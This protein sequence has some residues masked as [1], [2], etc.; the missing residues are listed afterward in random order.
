MIG[1]IPIL[2]CALVCMIIFMKKDKGQT[3]QEQKIFMAD[4][5]EEVAP[6]TKAEAYKKEKEKQDEK[7]R[8][9]QESQIMSNNAFYDVE[10]GSKPSQQQQVVET[11][12]ASAPAPVVE[13]SI[14]KSTPARA[15]SGTQ[16]QVQ[17]A[18]TSHGGGGGMPQPRKVVKKEVVEDENMSDIDRLL[19]QQQAAGIKSS[20][21]TQ[22]K[23]EPEQE[24]VQQVTVQKV[25]INPNPN[26]RSRNLNS[27]GQV[28]SSNLISAVI[29]NDQVISSGS[30]VKLRLCESIVVDGVTVPRNSFIT[31][32]ATFTKSRINIVLES[33]IVGNSLL[34]FN[35]SVY[36]K[37]GMQGINLPEN[38]KSEA[39]S[40][41]GADMANGSLNTL[42]SSMGIVG[43][44]LNS[45]KNLVRK[46]TQRQSITL[47]SNY[48]IFLK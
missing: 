20:I 28:V 13:R 27:G 4:S 34:P 44:A 43:A 30:N 15:A 40:E 1:L 42:T 41:A 11:P 8:I 14:P 10:G 3:T 26:G 18:S 25:K 23:V 17:Y 35:K 38:L 47:K 48:K 6:L 36:D 39:A 31:G 12:P 29:H 21:K 5:K 9:A 7:K 46:S 37:D 16:R 45:G 19:Q 32:V 2:L 33:I 24:Q 22:K